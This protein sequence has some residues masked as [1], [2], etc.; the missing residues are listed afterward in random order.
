[1]KPLLKCLVCDKLLTIYIY[2]VKWSE[3]SNYLTPWHPINRKTSF[4]LS[5][6]Y[7][8]EVLIVGQSPY[9]KIN[10]FFLSDYPTTSN[11]KVITRGCLHTFCRKWKSPFQARKIHFYQNARWDQRKIAPK[12]IQN[13]LKQNAFSNCLKW[14][15]HSLLSPKR[16]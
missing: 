7:V 11:F 4:L 3:V 8:W 5:L 15:P 14:P 1:M 10:L 9:L 2:I 16:V 6:G 12:I 13:V